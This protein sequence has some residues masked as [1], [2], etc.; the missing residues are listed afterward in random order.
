MSTVGLGVDIVIELHVTGGFV[1][2]TGII[3][4]DVS[5]GVVTI[6]SLVLAV[7]QVSV[8]VL[9]GPVEFVVGG[10]LSLFNQQQIISIFSTQ[11][12]L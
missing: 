4:P 1:V 7:V 2:V 5:L 9:N 10:G 12:A 6:T 11:I 8:I 3:S